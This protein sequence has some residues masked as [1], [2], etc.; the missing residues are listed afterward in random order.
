VAT[1]GSIDALLA[2]PSFSD[3]TGIVPASCPAGSCG[4]QR[5]RRECRFGDKPAIR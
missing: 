4:E 5:P 3:G 2:Q 1:S